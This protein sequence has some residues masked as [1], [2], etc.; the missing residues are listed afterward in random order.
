MKT[1]NLKIRARFV[2]VILAVLMLTSTHV[3]ADDV[4]GWKTVG[5]AGFS[6]GEAYDANIAIDNN[7]TLY[8]AYINNANNQKRPTVMKYDGNVW[9]AVGNFPEGRTYGFVIAVDSAGTPYVA[10]SNEAND[11]KAVVKKYD[12]DNWVDVGTPKFSEGIAYTF[13]MAIDDS[14]TPYV[15][16]TG[17]ANKEALVKKF[18]GNVWVD[19]GCVSNGEAKYV[20]IAID[21]NAIPYVVYRDQGGGTKKACAKKYE[22]GGWVDLGNVTDGAANGIDVAID[23]NNVPYVVYIEYNTYAQRVFVRKL[24]EGTWT[25]VGGRLG[26]NV[27]SPNIAIDKNGTPYIVWGEGSREVYVQKYEGDRWVDLGKVSTARASSADIALD[28]SGNPFVVYKDENYGSYKAIVRTYSR[29]SSACEITSVSCP[30][31]ANMIDNDITATV[32][33]MSELT[34]DVAVSAGASWKLYRNSACSNEIVNKTINLSDGNNTAYIKVIAED[35]TTKTYTLFVNKIISHLITIADPAG[36]TAT[37]TANKETAFAGQTVTVNITNIQEQTQFA[38][39][40]VND[41]EVMVKQVNE[42]T[43]YSFEM[44]EADV[45]VKVTLETRQY[46]VSFTTNSEDTVAEQ[47]VAYGALVTEPEPPAKAGCDFV[48]WYKESELTNAWNFTSD[49]VSAENITLY[50]KWT[51]KKYNVTFKDYDGTDLKSE[52]VE[53]GDSATAPT[54]PSRAGYTFAGWDKDF[55]KITGDLTVTARYNVYQYTVSF[56]T[57]SEDTV[58][59]QSVDYGA[60]VTEPEPPA[61]AGCDFVGWYKESELTNAWN[62]AA[63]TVPAENITLYAKWTENTYAVAYDGNG[64]TGGAVPTDAT[65]Y[66]NG[67]T[68]TVLGNIGSLVRTGYTF[69]DWNTAANGS[70]TNR[71][72]GETFTIGNSYITLFAQWIINQYIISFDSADG[73]EVDTITQD[74]AT[75]V[76]APADPTKEGCTFAGWSQ[77]IPDT[78]PA[79]NLTLTAQWDINQYTISFDSNGGSLIDSQTLDY[80]LLAGEPTA[81]TKDGYNFTG[82]YKEAELTNAWNFTSDTVPAGNITLYAKW[83]VIHHS[84]ESK[85]NA[86]TNTS[87]ADIYINGEKHTAGKA[88]TTTEKGNTKTTVTVDSEKLDEL[89]ELKGDGLRMTIPVMDDS[90]SSSGV[91]TGQM[92]KNMEDKE[93]ILEIKTGSAT[94]TLPAGEIDIDAIAKQFGES[95]GLSEIKVEVTIS[96]P[97]DDTVRIVENAAEEG[98]FAL[99]AQAVEFSVACT[100]SGETVT[101]EKF[102]AYVERAIEIPEGVN[103]NEITTAIVVDT[104]Q[105]TRHV[106]TQITLID[107]KYYAIINSLTNSVYTLIYNPVDFVDVEGHWA[108]DA[109]NDI[110]SRKVINGYADGTFAPDG[111]ITRAE[112]AAIIIRA[113]GLPE[114]TGGSSFGDVATNDWYCGSIETAVNYGLITGYS[115]GTFCP[116]DEITREQAMTIIVRAMSI[117]GLDT[118]VTAGGSSFDNF[119]DGSDVSDYAREGVLA[120]LDTG[121]ITGRGNSTLAP[122]DTI[123]RAEVAV[124]ARRLLRQSGLI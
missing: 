56:T 69:A 63:D 35:G 116:N 114:I 120:S 110:A 33:T 48:G 47:S 82:W 95:V 41:G 30:A 26:Y 27:Q 112:F 18:D 28:S 12:G 109:V 81:P 39:I 90:D 52:T 17:G 36:G 16:Y 77:D 13:D 93:A 103:P 106:P 79:E 92:V 60:L 97:S 83:T 85:T 86:G 20:N 25:A 66:H 71:K 118:R 80:G 46:T 73:T 96:E 4:F 75:A 43:E 21:N 91:L 3:S 65:S 123:T 70:G 89:L 7:G 22:D 117:T 74:Y 76:T 94:Y 105:T 23:G 102:N 29:L 67:D 11:Y 64:S 107:G 87:G 15:I 9:T 44:P 14:G 8:V 124:I 115:D 6:D 98:G 38:S 37:V 49:T 31:Q 53:H 104:D 108:Q 54:N 121:I 111:N 51:A 42:G 19:L 1:L 100:C 2:F 61:K 99:L 55:S 119:T 10:Y 45:T 113:L 24:I 5:N 32:S 57:N 40:T 34:V 84:T 72:G 58:P 68:V 62:F 59:D 78:M 101:V 50:A 88:E 122:N